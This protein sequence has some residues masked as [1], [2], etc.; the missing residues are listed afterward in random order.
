VIAVLVQ[1]PR[2]F[3]TQPG[4]ERTGLVVNAAVDD[5]GV[6]SGLVLRGGGLALENSDGVV[7]TAGDPL[8]G[9]GETDDP[10]AD[11]DEIVC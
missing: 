5:P 4:L 8:P 7:G 2:A 1:Q 3:D 9:D 6:V 11:H 10:G